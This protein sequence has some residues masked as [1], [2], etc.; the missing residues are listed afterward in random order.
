MEYAN[1]ALVRLFQFVTV[2]LFTFLVLLYFG[3]LV[4]LPFDTAMLLVGILSGVGIPE[5]ASTI[6]AFA[7]MAYL[8]FLLCK[9]RAL[10]EMVLSI[11]IEIA[12]MGHAQFLRFGDMLESVKK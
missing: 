5:I 3:L 12:L 1:M 7:L 8:G 4:F 9:M 2:V 10:C 6:L 11:G